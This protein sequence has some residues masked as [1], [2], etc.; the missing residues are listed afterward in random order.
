MTS[1]TMPPKYRVTEFR[2]I[3]G[4]RSGLADFANGTRNQYSWNCKG[5]YA[6]GYR[7]AHQEETR[8]KVR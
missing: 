6:D 2:F 3:D 4:Y 8:R 1:Y 5:L 7:A